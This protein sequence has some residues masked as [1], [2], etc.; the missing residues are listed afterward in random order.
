MKYTSLER[1]V[2]TEIV[3]LDRD[4][5]LNVLD[6]ILEHNLLYSHGYYIELESDKSCF[7]QIEKGYFDE[8]ISGRGDFGFK[9][10][11]MGI[12]HDLTVIVTLLNNLDREDLLTI[13]GDLDVKHIGNKITNA[14]YVPYVGFDPGTV[15]LLYW[16]ARKQFIAKQGLFDLVENGFLTEE[17]IYHNK[18]LR[19]GSNNLRILALTLLLSLGTFVSG[20]VIN[21]S[22]PTTVRLAP[23][24]LSVAFDQSQLLSRLDSIVSKN[25]PTQTKVVI[26]RKDLQALVDMIQKAL[27]K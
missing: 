4:G 10:L 1:K 17:E 11:V 13:T 15:E 7:L 16:Y 3:K 20:L 18:Q 21:L 14:E 8:L 19:Q 23:P 6:N 26:D 12:S 5:N 22:R 24:T 25:T 2:I 9:N 27:K